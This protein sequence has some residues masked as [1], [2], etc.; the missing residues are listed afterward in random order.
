MLFDDIN[1]SIGIFTIAHK[2]PQKRAALLDIF[3]S[4]ANPS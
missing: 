2:L 1:S 3:V 4:A